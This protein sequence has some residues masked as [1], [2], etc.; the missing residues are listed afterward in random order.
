M[1]HQSKFTEKIEFHSSFAQ[2]KNRGNRE[3]QKTQENLVS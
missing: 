3:D 1:K 2:Q